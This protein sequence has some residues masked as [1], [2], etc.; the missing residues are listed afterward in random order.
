MRVHDISVAITSGMPV[1]PGDPPVERRRFAS[2]DEGSVANVSQLSM[3]VHSGTH[4]DAPIHF[5]AGG[6]AIESIPLQ[7]LV[8]PCRVIGMQPVGRHIAAADLERLELPPDTERVLFKTTN[9]AVWGLKH[10]A[11][12][13]DFIALSIDGAHWLVEHNV[14]VVGIDYLSVEPVDDADGAVHRTLLGSGVV[15]I[16]GLNLFAVAPGA[17]TLVCLPLKLAGSDG[18]PARVILIEK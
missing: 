15:V 10:T 11:F 9:S 14:R 12:R 13:R 16:E 2:M 17:Y 3:S 7:T 1:W 6:S 5:V 18:A 8:G 4:V